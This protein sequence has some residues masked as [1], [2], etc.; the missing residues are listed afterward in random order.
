MSDSIIDGSIVSQLLDY[1]PETGKLFWLPRSIE[2]FVGRPSFLRFNAAFAGKEAFTA[3]DSRGYK[4]GRI[5]D[6]TYPGH[7]VAWACHYGEWPDVIDHINGDRSDNRLENMR[8]VTKAENA[9]HKAR[10]GSTAGVAFCNMR[11]K[12]RARITFDYKDTHIGYYAT[13]QEAVAEREKA[14]ATLGFTYY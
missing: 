3:T 8:N 6:K 7:R 4:S 14:N 13:Q 11:Q 9:R 1:E 2:H 12:W 10:N 5:Y